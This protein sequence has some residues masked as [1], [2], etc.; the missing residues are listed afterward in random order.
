LGVQLR[1]GASP[2]TCDFAERTVV[3]T[4]TFWPIKMAKCRANNTAAIGAE[5][6]AVAL[7]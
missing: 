6:V 7:S 1:R 5:M 2:D 4:P 3:A